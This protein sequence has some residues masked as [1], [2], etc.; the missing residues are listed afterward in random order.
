MRETAKFCASRSTR[1]A[2]PARSSFSLTIEQQQ[3]LNGPVVLYFA[4]GLQFDVRGNLYVM[5]NLANEIQVFA[6]DGKL[7][8]RHRGVGTNALDFNASAAFKGRLMFMTNMSATDGG[9]NSKLS[10]FAAPYR[11]LPTK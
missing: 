7:I 8:Q 2:G 1:T 9:V 10:V 5:A 3:Q 11:G 4:D 6:P